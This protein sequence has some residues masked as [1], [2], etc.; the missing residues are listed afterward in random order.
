VLCDKRGEDFAEGAVVFGPGDY[1]MREAD[2]LKRVRLRPDFEFESETLVSRALGDLRDT[3]CIHYDYKYGYYIMPGAEVIEAA[4][5]AVREYPI[6]L[7]RTYSEGSSKGVELL[8]FTEQLGRAFKVPPRL[9]AEFL[10]DHVA[11]VLN[12]EYASEERVPGVHIFIRKDEDGKATAQRLWEAWVRHVGELWDELMEEGWTGDLGRGYY[13]YGTPIMRKAEVLRSSYHLD[14][15]HLSESDADIGRALRG[16][17]YPR[18]VLDAALASDQ[19][20]LDFFEEL[21]RLVPAL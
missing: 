17:V 12:D 20:T 2:V 7:L 4:K 13:R 15:P 9:V 10:F 16:K 8:N 19:N 6:V 11:S 3:N 21:R 5:A 14:G 1:L 18:N